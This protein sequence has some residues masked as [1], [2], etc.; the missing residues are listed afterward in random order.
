MFPAPEALLGSGTGPGPGGVIDERATT[1]LVCN[2]CGNPLRIRVPGC[3]RGVGRPFSEAGPP[4][5]SNAVR[6]AE[7]H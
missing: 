7:G 5:G 2:T 1:A 3:V 6:C 4:T